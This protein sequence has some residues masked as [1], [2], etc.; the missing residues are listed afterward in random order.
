[1]IGYL[2]VYLTATILIAFY[3]TI[4]NYL[5]QELFIAIPNQLQNQ[6]VTV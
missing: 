3:P 2:V 6:F 4:C 1:M 5:K